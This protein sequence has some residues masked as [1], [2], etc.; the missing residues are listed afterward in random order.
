M[1]RHRGILG[2]QATRLFELR[3]RTVA[4]APLHRFPPLLQVRIDEKAAIAGEIV[5]EV[6]LLRR[7]ERRY[8]YQHG[9][10]GGDYLHTVLVSN[11]SSYDDTPI[12]ARSR[13]ECIEPW[14]V[15]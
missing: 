1:Q 5:A 10:H 3:Q 2:R 8:C 6:E 13:S 7:R 4:L 15:F 9:Q 11:T 12:P 14:S